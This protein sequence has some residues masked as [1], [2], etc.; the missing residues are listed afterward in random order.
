MPFRTRTRKVLQCNDAWLK[1]VDAAD[2]LRVVRALTDSNKLRVAEAITILKGIQASAKRRKYQVFLY[3]VLR[4][5][6]PCA[7]LLSAI[8]LG[9][10][11]VASMNKSQRSSL[12]E[13]L[14]RQGGETSL[15]DITLQLL[16]AQHHIPD[17]VD[18]A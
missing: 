18:G 5:G 1:I 17:T 13:K 11:N 7:V 2:N 3:D 12:A 8:A 14:G 4:K 6:G 9:Q 16:A 15:N 10:N